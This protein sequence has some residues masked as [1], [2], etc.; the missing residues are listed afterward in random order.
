MGIVTT[1][2]VDRSAAYDRV[3]T[4]IVAT[5]AATIIGL[6]LYII[7]WVVVKGVGHFTVGFLY[8][9]MAYLPAG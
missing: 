6:L 9:T 1:L 8:R 5:C 2:T 3:I 4:T 7:I